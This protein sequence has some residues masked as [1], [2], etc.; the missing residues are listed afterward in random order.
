[1]ALGSE[2]TVGM[3][4]SWSPSL[5]ASKFDVGAEGEVAAATVAVGARHVDAGTSVSNRTI[6]CFSRVGRR[7][8]PG[9]GG[10]DGVV[11][12]RCGGGVAHL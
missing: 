5:L 10:G 11:S 6:G 4:V 12:T 3:F 8:N 7:V 2:T 9:G 1:M